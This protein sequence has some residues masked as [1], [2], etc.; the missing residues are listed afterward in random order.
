MRNAMRVKAIRSECRL[1]FC[2][3]DSISFIMFVTR[4]TN[5][6]LVSLLVISKSKYLP[7]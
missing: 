6:N 5:F 2:F 4:E 3:Y 1:E 7:T